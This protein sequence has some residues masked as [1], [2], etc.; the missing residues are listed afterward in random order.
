M[1]KE[2][3]LYH[4]TT[5]ESLAMI[6]STKTF[7]FTALS[8]LDD[9][10]EGKTED[11]SDI[12]RTI[13][14]CCWTDDSMESIPMWNMYSKMEAGIRIKAVK[15]LFEDYL[16]GEDRKIKVSG[17]EHFTDER[18]IFPQELEQIIYNDEEKNLCSRIVKD[19]HW[20]QSKLGK[21]KR[22]AWEFQREW[23]YIVRCWPGPRYDNL[24]CSAEEKYK[25]FAKRIP[26]HLF[27]KV[28]P[29]VFDSLE[30][31]LSPKISDGNRVI[32]ELLK[33]EY[34]PNM[35]V[36]ESELKNCIR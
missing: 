20:N 34:C 19:N 4:Y 18:I 33:R 12:G 24:E 5:V 6:L 21:Y 8:D 28:K 31:T 9:L 10:Q 36:K 29:Q 16:I 30:I 13:F 26:R 35:I 1:G 2:E 14:V 32:I 27:L 17:Y 22:T 11:I 23:R 25:E 3:Y 7:R 15:H